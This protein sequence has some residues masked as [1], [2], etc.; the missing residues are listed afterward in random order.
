MTPVR[1]IT[2]QGKEIL[3]IDYSGST[4][5]ALIEIFDQAKL[6]VLADQ[7]NVRVLSVFNPKHYVSSKFIR[8]I[9]SEMVPVEHLIDKNTITGLSE[10]QKWIL[11][12]VNLWLRKKIHY[13]SSEEKALSFLISS[14][15][16]S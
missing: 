8:Y 1:K 16:E 2:H 5:D 7:K 3:V 10:T 12:G 4:G 11:K 13:F 6:M 14:D 9:E 15:T